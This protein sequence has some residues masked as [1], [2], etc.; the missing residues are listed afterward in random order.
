[1]TYIS[2]EEGDLAHFCANCNNISTKTAVETWFLFL[3]ISSSVRVRYGKAMV[4]LVLL[5]KKLLM[6]FLFKMIFYRAGKLTH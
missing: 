3:C 6:T 4:V 5:Q 1:M 2:L